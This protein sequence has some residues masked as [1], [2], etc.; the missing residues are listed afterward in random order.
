L[1]ADSDFLTTFTTEQGWP[2]GTRI[3]LRIRT[4]TGGTVVW[5]ATITD[6]LDANGD[7]V[8]LN[9]SAVF[10]VT[11][12]DVATVVAAK[13]SVVRLHYL[14]ASGDDLL[15]GVGRVYVA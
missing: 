9:G 3:E 13:P 5:A 4:S 15:W 2:D 14:D 11:E 12:S 10:D 8:V 7:V 1:A 6:T